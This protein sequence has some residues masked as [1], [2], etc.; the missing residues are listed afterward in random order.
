MCHE[1]VRVFLVASIWNITRNRV[2]NQYFVDLLQN[3]AIK[4]S[5]FTFRSACI[6]VGAICIA[7]TFK[8]DTR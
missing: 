2:K 6:L 5:I 4:L 8:M 3:R 1:S 7:P